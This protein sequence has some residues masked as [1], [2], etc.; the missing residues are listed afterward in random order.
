MLTDS[1]EALK[2]IEITE[3]AMSKKPIR[4]D[5]RGATV[6]LDERGLY[7][8]Q[9]LP[10]GGLRVEVIAGLAEAA[11]SAGGVLVRAQSAADPCIQAQQ[12]TLQPSRSLWQR[13]LGQLLR[14]SPG[15]VG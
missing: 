10:S 8:L 13:V 2:L 3:F 4:I 9:A 7:R 14:L 1:E 6:Y 11:T 5:G 15:D 12:L